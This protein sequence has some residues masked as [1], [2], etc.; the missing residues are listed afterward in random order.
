M[1]RTN[2]GKIH[3]KRSSLWNIP[4]H[5]LSALIY[6]VCA[7]FAFIP[8]VGY[9]AWAIA[10]YVFVIERNSNFVRFS[11]AQAFCVGIIRMI[12]GIVF[13]SISMVA[14]QT[15]AIYGTDPDFIAYWGEVANPGLGARIIGAI[16][17]IFLSL[18]S[19][20]AAYMAYRKKLVR[21]PLLGNLSEFLINDIKPP[22]RFR[23]YKP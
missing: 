18:V 7:A 17:A 11:A 13:D 23:V 21:I 1:I 16:F 5:T 20:Y 19:C 9:F 10:F 2:S 22:K 6:L 15:V 3:L 12:I 8:V 14:K 4:T